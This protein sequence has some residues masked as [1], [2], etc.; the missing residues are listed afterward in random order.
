MMPP[1][2]ITGMHRSG[3]SFA[4]SL[5]RDAGVDMGRRLMGPAR[6]NPLGHFENLDFTEFHMHW[7][8]LLGHDDA[9]WVAPQDLPLGE[10]AA[11]EAREKI[12]ENARDTPWGWKD[13]RTT[14]FLNFW[15]KIA[16]HARF[17]FVYREPGAVISSLF[18]RGDVS[19]GRSPELAARSWLSHNTAIL[20]F[21]SANRDRCIISNIDAVASQ[22]HRLLKIVA[23]KFWLEVDT[24]VKSPFDARMMQ[25]MPPDAPEATLLRFFLP[26]LGNAFAELEQAADLPSGMQAIRKVAPLAARKAFFNG[27]IRQL[28]RTR[29]EPQALADLD[30][31]ETALASSVLESLATLRGEIQEHKNAI[32]SFV[33]ATE[34]PETNPGALGEK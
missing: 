2:I 30:V 19:I 7:L 29:T 24:E 3:T 27:W 32:S 25:R 14:L 34:L 4:A 13:P 9:G 17:V 26:G 18:Q 16:P 5:F 1:L 10:E 20:A 12:A 8:R 21:A 33:D 23:E 11:L 28:T 15:N 22:P 31:E 6:G